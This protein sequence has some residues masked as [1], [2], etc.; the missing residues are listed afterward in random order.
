MGDGR[1]CDGRRFR[2]VDPHA[3][4][5]S[6]SWLALTLDPL[7]VAQWVVVAGAAGVG[8]GAERGAVVVDV[9]GA[10]AP[11]GGPGQGEVPAD[12]VR[13]GAGGDVEDLRVGLADLVREV[14]LAVLDGDGGAAVVE[15]DVEGLGAALAAAADAHRVVVPRERGALRD[16]AYVQRFQDDRLLPGA[17]RDE[18]DALLP[19][20]DRAVRGGPAGR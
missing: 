8:A 10:A 4:R 13:L 19:R 11:A 14:A 6:R 17:L 9:H 18:G 15:V 12:V 16:D 5:A 7:A 20:G 3:R 1:R 2:G